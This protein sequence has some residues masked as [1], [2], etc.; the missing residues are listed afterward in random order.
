MM[1]FKIVKK[2]T[3]VDIAP[4]SSYSDA[5]DIEGRIQALKEDLRKRKEEAERLRQL[6][7]GKKSRDREHARLQEESIRKQLKVSNYTWFP[8]KT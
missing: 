6:K 3:I 4:T 1:L 8:D 7:K 2:T 5:S